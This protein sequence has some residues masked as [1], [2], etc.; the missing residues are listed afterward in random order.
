MSTGGSG[1]SPA[2]GSGGG[3]GSGGGKKED[4]RRRAFA[5]NVFGVLPQGIMTQPIV[6]NMVAKYI[7][8]SGHEDKAAYQLDLLRMMAIARAANVDR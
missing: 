3:G 4:E 8:M 6:M 1:V 2:A 7:K 5:A